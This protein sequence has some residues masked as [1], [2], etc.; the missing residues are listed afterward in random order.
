MFFSGQIQE[1]RQ[2]VS[3]GVPKEQQPKLE[4]EEDVVEE[5]VETQHSSTPSKMSQT[6]SVG[7]S[8]KL[9]P[10]FPNIQSC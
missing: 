1:L 6:S 5:N 10:S 2:E 7:T 3:R 9:L 8:D 4:E